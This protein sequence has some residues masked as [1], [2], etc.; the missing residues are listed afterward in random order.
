M[1][2]KRVDQQQNEDKGIK[3]F[4]VNTA[5]DHYAH[6]LNYCYTASQSIV[7]EVGIPLFAP[8]PGFSGIKTG[9]KAND[10]PIAE[11]GMLSHEKIRRKL[12]G[13]R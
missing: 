6:A 1:A 8:L 5:P 7:E 10:Q 4:W 2:M 9:T 12:I 3:S 11:K 13:V